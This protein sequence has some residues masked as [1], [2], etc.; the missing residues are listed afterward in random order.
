MSEYEYEAKTIEDGGYRSIDWDKVQ[1]IDDIK[2][3]LKA[4]SFQFNNRN[5]HFDEIYHLLEK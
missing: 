2:A 3:V 4:L 5:K 1:T